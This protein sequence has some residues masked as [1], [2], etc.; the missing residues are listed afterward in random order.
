MS[1]RV[2]ALALGYV[3]AAGAKDIVTLARLMG[4]KKQTPNHCLNYFVKKLEL[5]LSTG[6]RSE[7]SRELMRK[8]RNKQLKG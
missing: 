8:S 3:S 5:P 2:M 4:I 1:T 7:Q 6:Q